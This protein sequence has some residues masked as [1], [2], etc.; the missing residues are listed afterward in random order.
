MKNSLV[1]IASAA[2]F[3][4]FVAVTPS[5]ASAGNRVYVEPGYDY[6]YD[7][8]YEDEGGD[9]YPQYGYRHYYPR[10]Y[11]VYRVPRRYWRRRARR[12]WRGWY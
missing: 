5:A 4:L 9:Y 12:Y 11:Y 2:T 1:L 6:P 7:Y 3:L 10:S 8:D